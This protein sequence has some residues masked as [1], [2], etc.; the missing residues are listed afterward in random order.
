MRLSGI[1]AVA[2]SAGV[3]VA[4][5]GWSPPQ[6]P[7]PKLD[8]CTPADAPS[9]DTVQRAITALPR[10]AGG[11]AWEETASGY[12]GD[13]RLNWVQVAPL[14]P[15]PNSPQQVLFFEHQTPLGP[16]TPQPRP[17]ISVLT[18]TTDDTVTVQYQWQQGGDPPCCPTG[19]GTVRFR[20]G[21]DGK[22][23]AVDP[24][25]NS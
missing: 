12:S 1:F 16:A 14:N 13:C 5:C 17:Y 9:D 19:I 21:D 25:P 4:G 7:P 2:L 24:I 20:I 11:A 15:Q 10:P 18:T 23:K 3:T 22:L 6:A 8:T